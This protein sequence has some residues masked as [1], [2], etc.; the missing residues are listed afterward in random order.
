MGSCRWG[1]NC[2]FSHDKPTQKTKGYDELN[3]DDKG[4]IGP[5]T[6]F[7]KKKEEEVLED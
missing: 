3:V 2:R 6:D 5:P 4:R 1:D 7:G